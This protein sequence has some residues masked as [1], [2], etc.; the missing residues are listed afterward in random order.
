MLVVIWKVTVQIPGVEGEFEEAG[1]VAPERVTQVRPF[2]APEAYT[3]VV[4]TP[5]VQVVV[6]VPLTVKLA[7]KLS[8]NV[9]FENGFFV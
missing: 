9:A 3:P 5:P 6:G 4:S 1:I 2:I 8:V 7:G